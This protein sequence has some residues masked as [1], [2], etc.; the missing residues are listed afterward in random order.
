MARIECYLSDELK[1]KI[2][3]MAEEK[4]VSTSKYISQVLEK[5]CAENS[6]SDL[7]FQ[8]KVMAIL[9]DIYA[10]VLDPEVESANRTSA[11]NRMQELKRQC[12]EAVA[13]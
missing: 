11:I 9:C 2:S 6:Q 8:K 5:H 7:I 13:S 1:E 12:E 10:C 3:K 4:S